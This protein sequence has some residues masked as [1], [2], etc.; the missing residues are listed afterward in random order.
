MKRG[1]VLLILLIMVLGIV[2][3]GRLTGSPSAGR[4]T[5]N[6]AGELIRV[7]DESGH[8][9]SVRRPDGS[10]LRLPESVALLLDSASIA[11]PIAGSSMSAFLDPTIRTITHDDPIRGVRVQPDGRVV[12]LDD[13]G[14]ASGAFLPGQAPGMPGPGQA[15]SATIDRMTTTG[16]Y[17]G[18]FQPGGMV[19]LLGSASTYYLSDGTSWSSGAGSYRLAQ[20]ALDHVESSGQTIR[21]VLTGPLDGI[22]YQQTDFDNGDHSSQGT[23]GVAGPLVIEA[24]AGSTTAVLRGQAEIR[25]NDATYYGDRFNFFSAPVGAIVPFE[26]TYTLSGTTWSQDTFS[27]SFTYVHWGQV[28]FAHPIS[29]PRVVALEIGGSAQVPAQA[30]VQF[31]ATVRYENDV[32]KSV[33][34]AAT[35][36]VE[37]ASLASI[38]KGLLVTGLP[39]VS[40][41]SLTLR[42][43]YAE[44]GIQVQAEKVVLLIEGGSADLPETWEMYQADSSHTG[45]VPVHLDPE[46]FTLRWQRTVGSGGQLNP[47]TAAGGMVFVSR[48]IYFGSG[49]SFFALDV[50]DGATLWSKDFGSVFSVNPPSYAYG[51]V[52][53][54]TGNH[55]SDTWLR[56][57]DA[58]TGTPIF[59]VPHAAQWERYYAPTIRDGSVYV[60]GGYYG[61]MYAF[62]AFSGQQRWFRPLQQYDQ[63]TPAVDETH[64]YAYVGEYDPGLYVVDRVT[65]ELAYKI[66]D[67]HFDWNG[68]SMNLAP[69]LGGA[70]NVLAIHDGRLISF[71]TVSRTIRWEIAPGFTGQPSVAHGA[72]YAI[73][74][75]ALVVLDEETGAEAWR[76]QPPA[77]SLS[78]TLIV[79]ESHVI[80]GTGS[81]TYAI[82]LLQRS[83]AWTFPAGG[84]L[85]LGD[86][87]LYIAS[88]NGMLT[89]I[90][91][92]G[93]TPAVLVR[94]EIAGPSE[95]L[96]NST[97][98]FSAM[99][100]YDD[101]RVRDRTLVAQWSIDPIPAVAIDANGVLT[102]AELFSPEQSV[103]IHAT[104]TENG[105]GVAA[106]KS[107]K[108]VIGVTLD[109]FV[110]RNLTGARNVT[111]RILAE[112]HE[113]SAREAA[114]RAVLLE[115]SRAGGSTGPASPSRVRALNDLVQ[116][117]EWSRLGQQS[118]G[119]SL[120]ELEQALSEMGQTTPAPAPTR[121]IANTP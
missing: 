6:A 105:V 16:G 14:A 24:V 116:A 99:A 104:Y 56:A 29:V 54:Q 27:G 41:A 18:Y 26:V 113:A 98:H 35:W 80:T 65:G 74:N 47:V 2:G 30:S 114:A 64:A 81:A 3:S 28:D 107:I 1:P 20:S 33:T 72:I 37:P 38:D 111:Q 97:G 21:Y 88:A 78:D 76:W 82:D 61:G 84:H 121:R 7:L 87:M 102:T 50:R 100:Y 79:T 90:S 25:S 46:S 69:V 70:H 11:P 103:T 77:G 45:W 92:P 9:Y 63:W 49:A 60:N 52:Y 8:D 108:V 19:G 34:D 75:G 118:F 85:A 44:G 120:S 39:D 59:R 58:G 55:G 83:L 51:N 4:G 10:L 31:S 91:M 40:P 36:T 101:G 94:L 73:R 53:I 43:T 66:P 5:Q 89:A 17:Y 23:L 109:E 86:D 13:P 42:A 62:D 106:E 71:D 57:Y 95:V 112:L 119:R 48:V 15:A 115:M 93:F 96:E 32:L 117:I 22:L 67:P 68:W 12:P 110:L